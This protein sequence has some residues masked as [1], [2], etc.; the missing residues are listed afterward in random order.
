[1]KSVRAT[2]AV[3]ALA[4]TTSAAQAAS[5][6]LDGLTT[7]IVYNGEVQAAPEPI[8]SGVGNTVASGLKWSGGEGFGAG[9]GDQFLAWC[10]DLIH[11]IRLG[12]T[13]KYEV[14][15]APYSNSYL[16]S[17]ADKR[18]SGLFNANYD[19]LD[20][21]D[22]VQAAA[23]Q[24][25]IWEVANDNDLDLTKG[26]FQASGLGTNAEDITVVAQ[27]FLANTAKFEGSLTWQ[28]LF[29]E[30]REAVGSQ[31]LVT[32]VRGDEPSI[33]P[34][35]LPAGMLLLFSGLGGIAAFKRRKIRATLE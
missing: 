16:L 9:L 22:P 21:S 35:P 15:D 8:A 4:T 29:L 17:G 23:F 25:A 14:V 20:A 3:I 26:A 5:I 6:T 12:E 24:L 7:P 33:T 13:Y 18:V 31:N 34:V 32:V 10:F 1:M 28:T 19:S 30:T 27:T 11:P 2:L